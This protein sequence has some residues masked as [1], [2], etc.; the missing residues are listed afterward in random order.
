MAND[1]P[2]RVTK[3]KELLAAGAECPKGCSELISAV[4]GI[5]YT[6][7]AAIMGAS[8]TKIGSNGTYKANA[9]DII[10]W[11][12]NSNVAGQEVDHVA[13]YIGDADCQIIDVKGKKEKPRKLSSYGNVD[14]FRSSVY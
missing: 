9:G 13:V 6:Q 11:L 10:G 8:P 1:R 12:A 2:T 7:A 14:V 3:A 4:L 5:T